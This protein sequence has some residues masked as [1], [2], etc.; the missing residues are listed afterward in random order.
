MKGKKIYHAGDTDFIPEMSNL[1]S[2]GIDMALLPCGG[3]YTMN[4]DEAL[5]AVKAIKPKIAVPM[6]YGT[7]EGTSADTHKFKGLAEELGVEVKVLG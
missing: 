5:Q 7:I 1:A 2:E 6:H 4:V 3:T